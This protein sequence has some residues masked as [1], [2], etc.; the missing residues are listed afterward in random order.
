MVYEAKECTRI[1]NKNNF[2]TL[3][4]DANFSTKL[5]VCNV[6]VSFSNIYTKLNIS[7]FPLTLNPS[8]HS[9]QRGREECS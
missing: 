2:T 8:N 4:C 7:V 5:K 3:T 1:Y 9:T 6:K